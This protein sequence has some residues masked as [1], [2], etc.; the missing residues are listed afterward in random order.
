MWLFDTMILISY[1]FLLVLN[2]LQI[3]KTCFPLLL[4]LRYLTNLVLEGCFGITDQILVSL[5]QRWL[6][7]KVKKKME[8]VTFL[9]SESLQTFSVLQSIRL[10][11]CRVTYLGL[12]CIGNRCVSL[13]ELSLKKFKGVTD[14]GL[15][16]I[17]KKHN[18]LKNLDIALCKMITHVSMAHITRSFGSLVSLKMGL[19][20]NVP[21]KAFVLTGQGCLF[22]KELQLTGN[23]VDDEGMRFSSFS[24]L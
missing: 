3:T 9:L 19:C 16:S 12:S 11:G 4:K 1:S 22:H 24:V 23:A 14:D 18:D 2:L 15:S 21:T 13:K 10:D 6:S 8:F 20:T 7:L 5:G 17:V